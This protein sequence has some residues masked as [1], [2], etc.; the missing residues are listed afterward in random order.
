[1]SYKKFIVSLADRYI[2]KGYHVKFIS[3]CRFQR[4]EEAIEEV[5]SE[6]GWEKEQFSA[7]YYDQNLSQCIRDFAESEIIIGTRFH[8]VVLGW[9]M[10]KKVLPVIYDSK[11]RHMLED[12]KCTFYMELDELEQSADNIIKKVDEIEIM[13]IKN[14]VAESVGQFQALDKIL[15]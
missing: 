11:T 1:M 10:G 9:L 15:K 3:F 13:D 7:C 5:I 12:N 4:D 14:L 6:G 8:S 2:Q